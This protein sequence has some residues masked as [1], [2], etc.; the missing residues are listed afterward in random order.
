MESR[1]PQQRPKAVAMEMKLVVGTD[2]AGYGP[3]LGPLVITA[4]VWQIPADLDCHA[5]WDELSSVL[6]NRPV[7][8]DRRLFVADSKQVYS[9]TA[10]LMDLETGVLSFLK[11][12]GLSPRNVSD[13]GRLLA[14]SSFESAFGTEP[15][16]SGSIPTLPV[17]A[18]SDEIDAFCDGLAGAFHQTGI[19]LRE[20]RS[21]IMFPTEF[22]RLVQTANS[23]G[24]VL[25]NATL[26]LIRDGVP[27]EILDGTEFESASANAV[28]DSD[29]CIGVQVFCDKHG[30][31]NRYDEVIAE[32]FDDRFV[33]RIEESGPKSRYRMGTAEFCFRTKAEELLPVALASMVAKYLRETLM[34]QL[35]HFWQQHV[36][37]LR[38]T[39][40][41]PLDA[42]RFRADIAATAVQ[43]GICDERLWRH[44]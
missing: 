43:L 19:R 38:P 3:N 26:Q 14:G 33:F 15:S 1:D 7:H 4:T 5:M 22:N 35:N 29:R 11:L 32:T 30:G 24:V 40:G 9:P 6:T 37:G 34:L 42:K 36:P 31:R 13:L 21:R 18:M 41:Y 2:E 25:S 23:K 44:R 12:L 20:I 8:N 10:G 17:E 39:K 16:S 27:N 28:P